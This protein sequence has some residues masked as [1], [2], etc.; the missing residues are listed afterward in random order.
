MREAALASRAIDAAR[1]LGLSLPDDVESV[2]QFVELFEVA[3][4]N[5]RAGR[6]RARDRGRADVPGW[7]GDPN[8]YLGDDVELPPEEV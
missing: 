4:V 3:V 7:A 5:Y 1:R 2:E 6:E 8:D